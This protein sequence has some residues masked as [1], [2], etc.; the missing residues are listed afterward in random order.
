LGLWLMAVS[1]VLI[2]PLGAQ[3]ERARP[4]RSNDQAGVQHFR[5]SWTGLEPVQYR[6]LC[7]DPVVSNLKP[8]SSDFLTRDEGLSAGSDRIAER[9]EVENPLGRR[10]ITDRRPGVSSGRHR[11][12]AHF[13]TRE[14]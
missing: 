13:A 14:R 1:V 3:M 5:R 10:R 9:G 8:A 12:G 7:V 11:Q 2:T 4:S 6:N